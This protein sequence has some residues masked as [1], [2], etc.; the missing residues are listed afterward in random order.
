MEMEVNKLHGY[1]KRNSMLMYATICKAVTH[2]DK[3]TISSMIIASDL[4][5]QLDDEVGAIYALNFSKSKLEKLKTLEL[6]DDIQEKI[7]SFYILGFNRHDDSASYATEDVSNPSHLVRFNKIRIHAAN[8][9]VILVIANM[10]N[11]TSCNP[12]QDMNMFTIALT[13]IELLS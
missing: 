11:F 12:Q 8:V 1:P 3:S 7:Y 4:P 10:M 2:I 13:R 9:M 6:D 5:G